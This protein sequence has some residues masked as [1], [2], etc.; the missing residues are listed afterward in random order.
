MFLINSSN[1][2][3]EQSMFRPDIHILLNVLNSTS[4]VLTEHRLTKYTFLNC[5]FFRVVDDNLRP[6]EQK[7]KKPPCISGTKHYGY[8]TPNSHFG[9]PWFKPQHTY[10][11]C[12]FRAIM[13][14]LSLSRQLPAWCLTKYVTYNSSHILSNN[15]NIPCYTFKV[16]TAALKTK[17]HK[18]A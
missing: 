3:A 6:I 8:C 12:C 15:Y 17:N 2:N 18:L 5:P 4:L 9:G 13:V 10:W 1:I 7:K 16:L 11:M 14:L